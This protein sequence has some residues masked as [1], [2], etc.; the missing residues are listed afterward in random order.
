V[1]YAVS[2]VL[3]IYLVAWVMYRRGWFVKV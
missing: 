3:A 1:L 2:N